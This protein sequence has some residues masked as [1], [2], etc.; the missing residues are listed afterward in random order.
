MTDRIRVHRRGRIT[1]FTIDRAEA[2]NALDRA[3]HFE[4]SDRLDAF[5]A[6]PEQWIVILTGAGERAFCAGNDLKQQ[7]QPGEALVPPTGFGGLTG[8]FDLTKPVIAAVN[9]LAFGGGFEMVLAADIAVAAAHARFALP[10]ARVG[11]A[12]MAGGLLRLPLHVG[13][14][15]AAEL[16]MTGKRL[17]AD[18]ALAL[19]LINQVVPEGQALDAAVAIAETLLLASP[20]ALRAS[21]AVMARAFDEDMAEAMAGH[22]AWPEIV[23]MMESEDAKEGPRAFT[24]K[25]APAWRGR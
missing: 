2:M 1:I 17:G 7:L 23:A 14:K 15:R 16:V 20:L 8:R 11:L 9:G 3:G 24:E 4:L 25:R 6:D 22:L 10:E 13:P 18:E 19:G 21:K 5:A 12:A